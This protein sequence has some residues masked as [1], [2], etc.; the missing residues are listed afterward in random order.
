[1][2]KFR[3]HVEYGDIKDH[4]D[5]DADNTTLASAKAIKIAKARIM[6]KPVTVYV[7]KVKVL[8]G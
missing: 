2:T 4:V 1:M 7:K 5:V 8:K 3:V 6:G